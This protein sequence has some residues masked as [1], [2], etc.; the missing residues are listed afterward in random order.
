MASGPDP[1]RA[2]VVDDEPLARELLGELLA[3]FP[4]VRVA[5]SCANGFEAVKAISELAPD[6]VFLD[7]QMP[8]LDGFEVLS[9]LP[10]REDGRP[11][12]VFVTAYDQYA[13]RAFDANAVDYLMKPFDRAR[14]ETA[15]ARARA[16]LAS[17]RA[18]PPASLAAEARDPLRPVSRVVVRDGTKITVLPVATIDYVKAE[19]DYVLLH[20]GDRD[21][22]KAETLASL[23]A[24]LPKDRFVRIH[25]SYLVNLD[26]LVRIEAGPTG[27][28]VAILRDG[29]SLPV[30]RTG[31]QRLRERI[32]G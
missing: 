3:T 24:Q 31:G 5:A 11:A 14:L 9:L 2:V 25:R 7:V 21:H 1:L 6:I 20:S 17:G 28:Q 4:D 12:V 19:D 18:A 29:T 27:G 10:R 15:I 16:R 13:V 22:L 30:S 8:R 23:E 26:R 32:G